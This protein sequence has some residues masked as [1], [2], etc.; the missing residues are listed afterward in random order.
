MKVPGGRMAEI[1]GT[2]VVFDLTMAGTA[3]LAALSPLVAHLGVGA[4]VMVRVQQGFLEAP[5]YP[6]LA[7]M[8]A[9]WAPKEEL[10]SFMAFVMLGGTSGVI[11]TFPL[12][13][14]ILHCWGWEAVFYVTDSI[15]AGWLLLW[16]FQGPYHINQDLRSFQEGSREKC[17]QVKNIRDP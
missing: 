11:V 8:I 3:V 5:S 9:K 16:T 2:K 1:S 15:T 12:C 7:A 10:S 6:I 13:G 14:M 17:K 4:M